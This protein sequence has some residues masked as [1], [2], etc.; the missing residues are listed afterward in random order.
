MVQEFKDFDRVFASFKGKFMDYES[1]NTEFMISFIGESRKIAF[2]H[3]GVFI[4]VGAIAKWNNTEIREAV[5]LSEKALEWQK[6]RVSLKGNNTAE[7]IVRLNYRLAHF[8]ELFYMSFLD[9]I[10]FKRECIR[11]DNY[12]G[13]LR[14]GGQLDRNYRIVK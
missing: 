8:R 5:Y 3:E 7:K 9:P 13:A 14:R 6:F 11:Y 2:D 4:D 1:S 12:L 10:E